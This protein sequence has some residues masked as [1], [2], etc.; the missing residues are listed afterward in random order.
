MIKDSHQK[1]N[2]DH[3]KRDAFLYIRQST[4]R[5]VLENEESTKRQYQ[6]REQALA[7]GW[8][9]EQIR[10]IDCDQAKSGASLAG[11][12]GFQELV[13]EVSMGKAGLVMGL[14]VSR[15]ARN[16]ADWHRLLEICAFT[17]TLILDQDGLY[18]TTSFNDRLLLGLKGAMSE[19]ELHILRGRLL[20]GVLNKARRGELKVP[21]PAGLEYDELDR[22]I[23]SRD[24]QIHTVF[25]Q[26]FAA[27]RRLGS[28]TAV[29]REFRR[30]KIEMPHYSRTGPKSNRII[31]GDL[32]QSQTLRILHNPRYAG[33]FAFGRIRT[34]KDPDGRTHYTSLPM[35]EWTALIRD[36]H[37][38]YIGW[39]EFE[40]NGR[41]LLK[42][43]FAY[44]KDN[45]KTPAREGSALLQ[46]IVIC[47][48]CG[49][50]MTVNYRIRGNA[51]T[52]DY[53]CQRDKIEKALTNGCQSISGRG[54][55]EKIAEILVSMVNESNIDA[56]LAVQMELQTR[57]DQADQIRRQ[58]VER[59]RYEVDLARRRY[60]QVD[61]EKRYVAEVLEADW[62]EKLRLL[63]GAQT[64]YEKARDR[65][66][67]LLSEE[68]THSLRSLPTD[69][70]AYWNNAGMSHHDR[71]RIIRLLI[72]D[73]TLIKGEPMTVHVRF[74]GGTNTTLKMPLPKPSYK[75]WQTPLEVVTQVNALLSDYT[76]GQIASILNERGFRSGKGREFS[77]RIIENICR[78]NELKS[79]F[80]RLREKG[81]LTIGEMAEKLEVSTSTINAWRRH[82]LLKGYFYDDRK[83]FLYEGPGVDKPFKCQG[84]KLSKRCKNSEFASKRTKEVQYEA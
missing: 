75:M 36:S 22:V 74:K 57:L 17:K 45:R 82:G 26:F 21:L 8:Q 56:A 31:W 40:A 16:N 62:N 28:A 65:D 10:V 33:A 41:K 43:A 67:L 76:F 35:K 13:A 11:R 81:L 55:D 73:V 68:Q 27:F 15:L 34:R 80:D 39:E 70:S 72:E 18:D 60:T 51:L 32:T 6:L 84:R 69:F 48:V 78:G 77:A 52:P 23:L 83:A 14:E 3:L 29:T 50:R 9:S 47:G 49:K 25:Q 37:P 7:L 54:I 79:R 5:Q 12:N 64:D 20:Q 38:G 19:A 58:Q 59:A 63:E 46:G 53:V 24:T 66:Q 61:P 4:M 30:E 44:G 1:I 42:N 71:K 2:S